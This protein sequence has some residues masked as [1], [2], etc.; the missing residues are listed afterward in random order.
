MDFAL[1][2]VLPQRSHVD[3]EDRADADES[4]DLGIESASE[5]NHEQRR[6]FAEVFLERDHDGLPAHAFLGSRD[7]KGLP[8][9][10]LECFEDS[11][12]RAGL[13]LLRLEKALHPSCGNYPL[14]HV[15]DQLPVLNGLEAAICQ[16]V[17][18]S[19]QTS[20]VVVQRLGGAADYQ[21]HGVQEPLLEY[22]AHSG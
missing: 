17:Y 13:L 22:A 21:G 6:Q 15:F 7:L 4:L 5:A 11:R 9:C 14:E 19:R 2:P 18:D 20:F 10:A 3:F 8:A 1:R 12:E 16:L